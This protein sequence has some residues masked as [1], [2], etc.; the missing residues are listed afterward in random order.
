MSSEITASL[1]SILAVALPF[2]GVEV[3][4]EQLTATLATLVVV[5]GGL[6]N[7]F[8]RYQRGGVNVLGVR[9]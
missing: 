3:G 7:W 5:I 8:K 2:F 6:Y 4:S 1:L 9:N